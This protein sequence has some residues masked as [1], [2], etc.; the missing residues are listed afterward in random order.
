M[1]LN[2]ENN[3]KLSELRLFIDQNHY[4]LGQLNEHYLYLLGKG[5]SCSL[6]HLY[7]QQG[8]TPKEAAQGTKRE[9]TQ[10]PRGSS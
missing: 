4:L 1:T 10:R 2:W 9:N 8:T 6:Q 5:W 3:C 7:K